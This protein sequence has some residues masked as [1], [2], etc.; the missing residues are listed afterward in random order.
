MKRNRII[1]AIVCVMAVA[2][3]AAGN[4][5]VEQL[6]LFKHGA[7]EEQQIPE[8]GR[9]ENTT[10]LEQELQNSLTAVQP[11]QPA[12]GEDTEE[13]P[14]AGET[15][16]VVLYF[17]SADGTLEEE[18]RE[19]PKEDGIARA[20]MDQLI[21]GPR[22]EDLS[23]TLPAD[24]ELLDINISGGLCTVDFSEHLMNGLNSSEH[25]LTAL[26]SIVNTLT[27]F[28]SVE[29][30]QVLVEGQQL[31]EISGVDASQA[32]SPMSF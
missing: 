7:A 14:A 5:W 28:D 16:Q 22:E 3:C 21:Q 1:A 10:V 9:E 8:E 19:I 18:D 12:Q 17:A 20:T 24:T 31:G 13:A 30:V 29:R 6:Q 4:N 2:V 26:Y 11:D 32:M 25:Q 15:R 27:Q 23:A